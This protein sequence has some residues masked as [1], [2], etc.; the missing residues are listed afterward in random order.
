MTF[1][2]FEF[3]VFFLFILGGRSLLGNF[4][5][6]KWFLLITSLFF[7]LISSVSSAIIILF[8]TLMD[9]SIGRRMGQTADQGHRRNL[10]ILSLVSSL[11]LLGFFKYT[12]FLLEN[13]WFVFG[14]LGFQF[15][16]F[17]LNITAPPGISFFTFASV[18]YIIDVYYKRLAP[19]STLSDYALFLSF[20][21]KFLSGPIARAVNFLPQ[22][23]Q[24]VQ[25]TAVDIETGLAY[26]LSGAVKKLVIADQIAGH[27]NMIF[28]APAQFDGFTLLQGL[29][30]YAVQIYCDFAGYSE[31]AIGLARLLGFKLPENFQMPYAAD[32]ITEFWR[33]WHITMSNWF[34]DYL[35]FPLE[36]ARRRS[37]Y[38]IFRTSSNLI[39]TWLICGLWHGA[40]W[41][42]VIWGGIHACA[43]AT[44]MVWKTWNPLVSMQDSRLF[45][46]L[47]SLFS[48]LLTLG[49]LLLSLIFFRTESVASAVMYLTRLISWSS[50]GTNMISPYIL[51]AVA[52]VF[53][54]HLSVNKD[55]NWPQEIPTKLPMLRLLA[56]TCLIILL[57]TL[58]AT[59]SVPFVYFQF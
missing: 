57:V 17:K 23:K 6:A 35:F 10:L 47:W 26:I 7:C 49:V 32:T 50:Q 48:R 42:Y 12:N 27:V 33:R 28:S 29:L 40:G 5:A 38:P 55:R 4:M 9:F 51:S 22:L 41:N 45:Q 15:T 53:L 24:R 3:V 25:L 44:H 31:M 58:G 8:I 14:A 39:V 13:I 36:M 18:S 46:F 56:Y 1:T 52:A 34:R 2:S 20:F 43:M 30:G 19:C 16:Q 59:D 21:P 54:V 11:G 37:L